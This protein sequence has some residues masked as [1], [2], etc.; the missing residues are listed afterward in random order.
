MH[1]APG[2]VE[3]TRNAF[4]SKVERMRPNVDSGPR[5]YEASASCDKKLQLGNVGVSKRLP[6]PGCLLKMKSPSACPFFETLGQLHL[7]QPEAR[8]SIAL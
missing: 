2:L 4:V 7:L 5:A 1:L 6:C 3:H 8:C